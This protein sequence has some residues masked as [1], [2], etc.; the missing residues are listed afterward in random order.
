[1]SNTAIRIDYLNLQPILPSNT[2]AFSRWLQKLHKVTDLVTTTATV[3]Y[4]EGNPTTYLRSVIKSAEKELEEGKA[5]PLFDNAKEA[6]KWL[7]S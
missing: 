6:I 4:D 2:G 5:P 7:N 3:E 1:M